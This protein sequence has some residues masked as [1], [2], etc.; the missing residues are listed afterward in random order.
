MANK[1]AGC[2]LIPF[3]F[4]LVLIAAGGWS[5]WWFIL[6]SRLEDGLAV[7]A[8]SLRDA[9]WEVAYA[10]PRIDGYPFRVRLTLN[11]LNVVGPSG[12]GVRADGLQAEALAYA[13]DSWVI[14]APEGLSLGRGVK[15]WVRV[16]GPALRA[17]ISNVQSRPPR[18]VVEFDQAVFTPEPG[19]QPF[20]IASAERLVI[21]LIPQGGEAASAGL[22]FQLVNAE[23][24]PGGTLERMAERRPF[25]LS[26]EAEI[27]QAALLDGRTWRQALSAWGTNAGSLTEV[28]IEATAG[29]DYVRGQSDRLATDANGRLMGSLDLELRGGTAP[30]A[31]LADA[32]GVDPRAAAAVRFGARL[33]SGL[34][35]RTDLPLRFAEGRTYVGPINLGPAPKVY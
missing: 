6:S 13:L 15:G 14:V 30:L 11:D 5:V 34:R 4:L 24:R 1:R 20:P 7:R 10:P 17:S 31:G 29:E 8:Q 25:N 33:T 23:G 9:G 3:L 32:P 21:N 19:A 16:T 18:L 26:A 12:H 27:D 28:R 2:G 35:G 22:L